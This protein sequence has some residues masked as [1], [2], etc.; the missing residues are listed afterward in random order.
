MKL[1]IAAL[2]W[3]GPALVLV[4]MSIPLILGKIP[5]NKMYGLRVKKTL[6]SP[7]IWY[8]ANQYAGWAML[9]AGVTT[10]IMTT[11]LAFIPQVSIAVYGIV[12]L[13][14]FVAAVVISVVLSFINLS[15]L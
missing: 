10:L 3:L 9:W 4:F 5:P 12:C 15:R 2:L 1:A 8:P 6:E 11:L 14:V 13:V 7:D